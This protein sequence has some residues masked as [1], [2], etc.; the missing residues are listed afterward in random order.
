MRD[1]LSTSCLTLASSSSTPSTKALMADRLCSR[2][3]A[4]TSCGDI[5]EFIAGLE[6][7]CRGAISFAEEEVAL[8]GPGGVAVER[9]EAQEL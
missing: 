2:C 8:V 4:A 3:C 5:F 7:D 1:Q 9:D 6:K